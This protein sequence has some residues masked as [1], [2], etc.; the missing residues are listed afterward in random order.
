MK[1]HW[2]RIV[3]LIILL[4]TLASLVKSWQAST[5]SQRASRQLT[6]Y[7][8]CQAEWTGFLQK[9]LSAAR[10]VSKDVSLAL[11]NLILSVSNSKSR[12]ETVA[13]INKYKEVRAKQKLVLEQNPLPDP[14]KEV[15]A[16]KEG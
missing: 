16:L 8:Q 7:V 9:A 11:D 12:E 4:V 6:A 5:E 15:C 2:E 1:K 3:G 13:A 10:D 14:P